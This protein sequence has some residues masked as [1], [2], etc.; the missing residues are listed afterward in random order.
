MTK[1]ASVIF[2]DENGEG[3]GVRLRKPLTPAA[4]DQKFEAIEEKAASRDTAGNSSPQR[5]MNR[6][7]KT[8]VENEK[9]KMR[10]RG[11]QRSR[12]KR[13][14]Q[15]DSLLLFLTFSCL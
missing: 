12:I 6:L 2:L 14:A 10:T 13:H 1:A 8:L 3:L 5:S 9:T 7:K 11:R 4:L 15:S